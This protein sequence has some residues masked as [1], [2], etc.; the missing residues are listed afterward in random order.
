MGA[1]EKHLNTRWVAVESKRLTLLVFSAGCAI[2]S[3][4]GQFSMTLEDCTTQQVVIY[5]LL[6]SGL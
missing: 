4:R 2:R 1:L 6:G 5:I 3:L